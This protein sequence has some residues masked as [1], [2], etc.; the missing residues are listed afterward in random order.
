[1]QEENVKL[2]KKTASPRSN[3][4]RSEEMRAKLIAAARQ[5]FVEKGFAETGTPEIVRAAGVT[6][7]A[8]YHHFKDKTDLFRAVVEEEVK[9]IGEEIASE[10]SGKGSALNGLLAGTRGY[11]RAVAVPGRIRLMLLDAPSVIGYEEIREMEAR[12]GKSELQSGL[13]YAMD[14]GALT[15]GPAGPLAEILSAAF[16]RAAIAQVSDSDPE[17][18]VVAMEMLLRELVDDVPTTPAK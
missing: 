13:Q 18:Y 5:L 17:Q 1:M 15:D 8:L 9:A 2:R 6:R 3:A 14:T 10:S 11:F 12:Y 4:R 7:G 16:D